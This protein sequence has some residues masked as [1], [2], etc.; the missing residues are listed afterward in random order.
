MRR[1]EFWICR[2][3]PA[4]AVLAL[5]PACARWYFIA[6]LLSVVD[7]IR[8]ASNPVT[9]TLVEAPDGSHFVPF[10]A[11]Q[12]PGLSGL[13]VLPVR[14]PALLRERDPVPRRR[15]SGSSRRRPIRSGGSC[16]TRE[17][18]SM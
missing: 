6:F 12:G 5:G 17:R 3:L 7:V 9:A 13:V 10:D 8:R 16:W 1:S 4:E 15:R 14:R 11:A 18:W 2:S